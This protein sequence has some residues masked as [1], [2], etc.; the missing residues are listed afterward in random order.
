MS[1]IPLIVARYS[2]DLKRNHIVKRA[3]NRPMIEEMCAHDADCRIILR[4]S[5]MSVE[6]SRYA[7]PAK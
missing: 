1:G 4:A 7:A 6:S 2:I 3:P 5:A